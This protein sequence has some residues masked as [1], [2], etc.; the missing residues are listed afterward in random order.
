MIQPHAYFADIF[1][2]ELDE[3]VMKG[4]DEK[5]AENSGCWHLLDKRT[6]LTLVDNKLETDSF[7]KYNQF[8]YLLNHA[9]HLWFSNQ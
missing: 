5:S 8:M 4:L 9:T 2:G 1:T 7:A 3:K 6:F